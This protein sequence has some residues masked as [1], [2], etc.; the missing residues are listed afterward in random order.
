M[1]ILFGTL[2]FRP[3]ALIPMI[4][5]TPD[6]DKVVFYHGSHASSMKARSEIC[7]YCESLGIVAVPNKV[8]DEFDFLHVAEKMRNDVR[9]YRKEGAEIA[10]FNIAGGT[11]LMSSAALLISWMLLAVF[12]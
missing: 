3:E 5:A 11:K 6:V 7:S 1:T 4:K 8:D 9:R 10:C 12:P 2:G